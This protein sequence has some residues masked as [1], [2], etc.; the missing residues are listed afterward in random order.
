MHTGKGPLP[1][2][3]AGLQVNKLD[4]ATPSPRPHP[5]ELR[6]PRRPTGMQ[7]NSGLV[8]WALSSLALG[9]AGK[10]YDG[11]KDKKDKC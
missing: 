6:R 4:S 11:E 3:A 8:T 5:S 9:Q 2:R 7:E 10:T 1:V